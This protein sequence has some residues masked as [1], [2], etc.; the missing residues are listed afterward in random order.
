MLE[1]L[2]YFLETIAS[3][4][5]QPLGWAGFGAVCAAL[6]NSFFNYRL[7]SY[8]YKQAFYKEIIQQRLR[9]YSEVSSLI[10]GIAAHER[11]PNGQ[12]AFLCF[13][14]PP[15]QLKELAEPI[16]VC[17]MKEGGWLNHGLRERL[18]DLY[19]YLTDYAS[20]LIR[21]DESIEDIEKASSELKQKLIVLQ[22]E[23][24]YNFFSIF[25]VQTFLN[26]RN[27]WLESF[28]G[29]DINPNPY[30]DKAN[31]KRNRI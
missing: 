25:D 30:D 29:F 17:F 4:M 9:A 5:S 3:F 28:A 21:E 31:T 14:Y 19:D 2:K 23:L 22:V 13:S 8:E 24:E 27:A 7:K 6:V 16:F 26:E 15:K 10:S 1:Q 20:G 18:K 11:R 12:D